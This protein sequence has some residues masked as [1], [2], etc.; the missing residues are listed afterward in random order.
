MRKEKYKQ[1]ERQSYKING[2]KYD[3]LIINIP[4]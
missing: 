4:R 3:G 1:P 2:E